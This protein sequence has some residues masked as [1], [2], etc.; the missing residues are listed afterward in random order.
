MNEEEQLAHERTLEGMRITRVGRG[1]YRCSSESESKREYMIDLSA[2]DGLGNCT[3]DDFLYRRAIRWKM[4][5]KP[6]D[7]FR[8]KHLRRVRNHVLDQI[9]K[10]F[11]PNEPANR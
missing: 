4:V 1:E 11:S 3:C 9:I 2:N 5:N 8:C 7:V 6:Y 10:H